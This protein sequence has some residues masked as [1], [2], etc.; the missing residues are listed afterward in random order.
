MATNL[1]SRDIAR[2]LQF[3]DCVIE[4][5]DARVSIHSTTVIIHSFKNY[6]PAMH[7]RNS[8]SHIPFSGRN[9]NLKFM[10]RGRPKLL[11]LNKMDLADP[12][13]SKV[14]Y[15]AL[16]VI[17]LFLVPHPHAFGNFQIFSILSS[18]Y[19]VCTK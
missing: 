1:G 2:R 5:H 8:H 17:L 14:T 18:W 12:A 4:V 9:P 13:K 6:I 19:T 15:S 3:C 16:Q 7:F 10:L 11:V